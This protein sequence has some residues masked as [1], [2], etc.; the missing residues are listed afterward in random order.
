[1][2]PVVNDRVFGKGLELLRANGGK[3]EINQLLLARFVTALVAVSKE[4][5]GR[6]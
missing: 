5:L 3:F 1:M 4:K 2:V 6:V